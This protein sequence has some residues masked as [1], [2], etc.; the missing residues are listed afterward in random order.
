MSAPSRIPELGARG[1]GWVAAQLLLLAGIAASALVG[2]EWPDAWRP[3]A[4][5]V[6]GVLIGLGLSLVVAGGAQLGSSLT[7]FPAPRPGGALVARGLYGRA[8]HPMYGGGILVAA[9]WSLVFA[10][11]VGGV[12]TAALAFFF[13][14]KTRREEGWLLSHHPGYDDYRRRT[15]RRFL[16]FVY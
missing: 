5:A 6:G 9:G 15:T 4:Y 16:P 1:G 10:T 8:R 2:L 7:P 14:L 13:E 3:E 11:V 12:L